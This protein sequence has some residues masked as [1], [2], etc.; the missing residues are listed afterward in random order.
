MTTPPRPEL[1]TPEHDALFF[2]ITGRL[3]AIQK[4]MDDA[5]YRATVDDEPDGWEAYHAFERERGA[6]YAA[7]YKI[8][9][10]LP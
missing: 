7:A 5:R 4:Q 1:T 8:G 6:L 9:F 3:S 10:T 2:A